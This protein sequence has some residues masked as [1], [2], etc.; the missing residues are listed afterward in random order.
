MGVAMKKLWVVF[1]L[2]FALTACGNDAVNENTANS[3]DSDRV[4]EVSQSYE[5]IDLEDIEGYV[6]EGYIVADVREVDEYESGHIP[7]AINVPLSALQ[8]GDFS[9]LDYDEKYVIICR[10][11]NRSVTASDILTNEGFHVVNVSEGM[12]TWTGEVE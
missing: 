9:G 5:T 11:G 6:A 10:S 4:T 2:L 1:A 7:G 12:S 8:N 3:V